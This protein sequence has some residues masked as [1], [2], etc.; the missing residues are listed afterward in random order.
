M[1]E[2]Q[3]RMI[4]MSK[5]DQLYYASMDGCLDEGTDKVV[6]AIAESFAS[7]KECKKRVKEILRQIWFGGSDWR[8]KEIRKELI[9][10]C[11]KI[12][13]GKL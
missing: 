2:L 9:D 5:N 13:E 12:R 10:M 8:A 6:Q 11:D 3:G 7:G 4:D 1:N